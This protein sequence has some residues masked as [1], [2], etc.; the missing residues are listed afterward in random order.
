MMRFCLILLFFCLISQ[1]VTAAE[2]RIKSYRISKTGSEP[3]IDGNIQDAAWTSTETGS[4]FRQTFP[5]DTSDALSKTNFKLCYD[6][7][8]L[9][10]AI[11]CTNRDSLHSYVSQTLRRDFDEKLNDGIQLVLDPFN[12]Q[13][14][15]FSF[16]VSPYN[17]QSEGL[18]T[19]G[20]TYGQTNYW[21]N[22]WYSAVER[23]QKG[24]T[25]ELAI[26]FKSIRF[27]PELS[28]WGLNIA[29]VDLNNNEVS[30]W[31]PIPRTFSLTSLAFTG[32]MLW[33]EPAPRTGLNYSVIPYGIAEVNQNLDANE[34]TK[35]RLSAGG[36]AKIAVSSSLNLDVTVNPDF[37][38]A[39]VDR[40]VT[41][42]TRFSL[43]FPE[44]R[45]FFLEN[46]D[47]FG[48]FGFS[49][50]RP[51]FSRQIGLRNGQRV[52][53][54]F[55]MRLSGKLDQ[56][57]RI[58]FMNVQTSGVGDVIAP[59]NFTV[60][61]FQRQV[62]GRSNIGG[63]FVNRQETGKSGFTPTAYNRVAGLDY[64]LASRNGKWNGIA[65]FHK[66]FNPGGNKP[67]DYAH[68]SFLRYDDANWSLMWN[69]EYVGKNY[70]AETGF[71][72]RRDQFNQEKD[73]VIS[74][75]YWRLEPEV[76]FRQYLRSSNINRIEYGLYASLYAD[77][78]LRNTEQNYNA[79]VQVN[80]TNSAYVG[81]NYT[82]N[83]IRLIFPLDVTFTGLPKLPAASYTFNEYSIYGRTDVRKKINA[84]GTVSYGG[85]YTGKKQSFSGN[86]QFRLPPFAILG[87]NYSRD[88]IALGVENGNT[89]LNLIGP[90]LDLS[91]SRSLFFSSVVQ[92]NDQ[93]SNMNV[94]AR[95]QWRF[96]PMSDAFLVF[97]NNYK[98]PHLKAR[99]W[100]LVGKLI[101]WIT[102]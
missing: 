35:H 83:R 52:P 47:L 80:Y 59:E 76:S 37:S 43:F 39:D 4:G 79:N 11:E 15:G 27:D 87:I 22:R 67:E 101:I 69:H 46:S 88:A 74:M 41:N 21:D 48:Q 90:S 75:T 2:T 20:G 91:F 56:N 92:Y 54:Q 53:I 12:D 7:N 17:V 1:G 71:V 95:L 23:N 93:S 33:D 31:N 58:G 77:S 28:T 50:I 61:C 16:L 18:I 96:K 9:Y 84:S 8:F 73:E 6:A 30:C 99:N 10:V 5:F 89:V 64:K 82:L 42:L 60:A 13:Y 94:F 97:T 45:Q 63:I 3:R 57:W 24:W 55:G 102:P 70:R 51:F 44:R 85:F 72:P 78:M 49:K 25:A 65:F 38:Q 19:G 40:Q 29:R 34:S 36:D 32:K 26:P 98:T 81:A 100:A 68:A 86:L 62:N 66:S 14:N